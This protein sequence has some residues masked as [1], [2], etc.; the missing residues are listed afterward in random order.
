ML[1]IGG[2]PLTSLGVCFFFFLKTFLNT[3]EPL[4]LTINLSSSAEPL[5]FTA[6]N[7]SLQTNAHLTS[8]NSYNSL[9]S[10]FRLQRLRL[11]G[12]LKANSLFFTSVPSQ[13][14]LW[15]LV[16]S[17]FSP[18]GLSAQGDV[19]WSQMHFGLLIL[20]VEPSLYTKCICGDERPDSHWHT[21]E[22]FS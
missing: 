19:R 22:N 13:V 16:C 20:A 11:R 4:P 5:Q 6:L 18:L 8:S 2:R 12:N 15:G 9:L 14:P 7:P 21:Q 17:P 3:P 10:R 1:F